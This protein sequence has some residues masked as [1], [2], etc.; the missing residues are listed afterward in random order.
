[1]LN[2]VNWFEFSFISLCYGLTDNEQKIEKKNGGK[3]RG[4]VNALDKGLHKL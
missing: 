1:M 3:R 2:S 4:K